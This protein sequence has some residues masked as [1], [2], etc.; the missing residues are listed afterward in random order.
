[1]AKSAKKAVRKAA[2]ASPKKKATQAIPKPVR[3]EYLHHTTKTMEIYHFRDSERGIDQRCR[4]LYFNTDREVHY[5]VKDG[6]V[7]TTYIKT[8]TFLGFDGKLPLGVWKNGW[9]GLHK[10]LNP[11]KQ[12]LEEKIGIEEIVIEKGGLTKI[13]KKEHILYLNEKNMSFFTRALRSVYEK[14][15]SELLNTSQRLLS[16]L[17]P[18]DIQKPSEKY[19]PN[20]LATSFALWQ[21]SMEEFS[22]LDKEALKD[23]FEKLALLPNFMTLAN[24]SKTKEIID[25]QY[26]AEALEKFRGLMKAKTDGDS[27]EKRWQEYLGDNSWVFST[28]FAQPVILYQREAYVGGKTIQ[29]QDGKFG[30]FLI[31]NNLS[32]NAAFLEIKTHLTDIVESR[33]YRGSDVFGASKELSGCIAQVL[34]QRDTF[35]KQWAMLTMKKESK[36]IETFNSKAIILIGTINSLNADQKASF[37]LIRSNSRDVEILTFDELG[38]KIERLLQ[39]TTGTA[40][41]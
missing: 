2:T 39:I 33:P 6:D 21:N 9:Y 40:K 35:Q 26:I 41:F 4:E 13:D 8:I 34:Q 7:G 1:M 38:T 28:I 32:S 12:I 29:N 25:N 24:I 22:D 11:I 19:V 30:D 18:K 36:D 27:L 23:L 3:E 14:H 20:S 10:S 16:S 37:E 5:I 31:Q 17:F 15:R